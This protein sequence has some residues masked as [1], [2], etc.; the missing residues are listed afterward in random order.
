MMTM[1]MVVV[2][3]TMMLDPFI[4][5]LSIESHGLHDTMIEQQMKNKQRTKL[6]PINDQNTIVSIKHVM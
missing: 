3:M 4:H 6:T 5:S 2:E 1:T